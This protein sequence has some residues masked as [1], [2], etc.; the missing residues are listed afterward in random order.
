AIVVRTADGL[1]SMIWTPS[2]LDAA[3]AL[4]DPRGTPSVLIVRRPVFRGLAGLDES[5]SDL[6]EYEFWLRLLLAGHRAAPSS[7]PVAAREVSAE[8]AGGEGAVDVAEYRSVLEK[9]RAAVEGA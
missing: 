1:D 7:E 3:A 2:A 9:H 5:L 6:S 4:A 8:G